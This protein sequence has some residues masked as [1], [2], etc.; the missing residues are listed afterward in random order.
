MEWINII[1]GFL[2]GFGIGKYYNFILKLI[3]LIKE[4]IKK[5]RTKGG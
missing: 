3:E 2:I 1:I 4:E 5:K